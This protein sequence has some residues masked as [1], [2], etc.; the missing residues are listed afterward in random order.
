MAKEEAESSAA[1][2]LLGLIVVLEAIVDQRGML[3]RHEELLDVKG[4]KAR[5]CGEPDA[6]Q[7]N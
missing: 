5:D 6:A 4:G 3:R 7:R 1:C 2:G